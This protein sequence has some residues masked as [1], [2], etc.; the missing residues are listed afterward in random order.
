MATKES[1]DEVKEH[2]AK[3]EDQISKLSIEAGKAAVLE[4]ELKKTKDALDAYKS[5]GK[6]VYISKDKKLDKFSGRPIKDTDPTA[7]EWVEGANHHLKNISGEPAQVEFLYDHLVGQAK[8]E[9][10]IRP[11]TDRNT[12]PKIL[13]IIKTVFEDAETVGQLQQRFYQRC[14]KPNESL[15]TYSLILM[16]L[17]DRITKKDKKVLG[18]RDLILKERFVDGVSDPLLRREMKRFSFEHKGLNFIDF[19]QMIL[20]WT[21]DEAV[22]TIKC[23]SADN[24]DEAVTSQEVSAKHMID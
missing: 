6:T 17:M 9:I 14:Q 21:E 24:D 8:D 4:N 5:T 3:F 13:D 15:Q 12:A 1:V 2:V 10:R 18:D 16:K 19:R 7:H 11:E 20:K 23:M 22:A